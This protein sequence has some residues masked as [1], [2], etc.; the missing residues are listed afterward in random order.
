MTETIWTNEMFHGI[1]GKKLHVMAT[2]K[3]ILMAK[4]IYC[5]FNT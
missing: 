1:I 3:Y 5:F 2:Y 4:L